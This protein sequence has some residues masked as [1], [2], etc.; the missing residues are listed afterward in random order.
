MQNGRHDCRPLYDIVHPL[1]QLL[2][3]PLI[4]DLD[5]DGI[6]VSGLDGSTVHFDYGGDGFAER[7]GWVSADDGLLAIDDNGNG[8][9]DGAAELFGSPTQDGF[10]VLETLDSNHDGRIDARDAQFAKLRVWRDLNQNG[11]SDARSAF[12]SLGRGAAVRRTPL[13]HRTEVSPILTV[14]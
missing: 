4:L 12:A 1:Q 8:K 2:R 3:D 9:V 14:S 11:V 7:T 13:C 10:A 5:G 6:E